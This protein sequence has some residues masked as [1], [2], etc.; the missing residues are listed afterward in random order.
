MYATESEHFDLVLLAAD[1]H[2]LVTAFILLYWSSFAEHEF[3]LVFL[4]GVRALYL[5]HCMGDENFS[6]SYCF[7]L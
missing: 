6:T 2:F 5:K 7:L 3:I 1:S 4:A